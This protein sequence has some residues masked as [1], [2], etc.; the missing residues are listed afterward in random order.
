[1]IQLT[2]GDVRSEV[3]Q[4]TRQ[5]HD[6]LHRDPLLSCLMHADLTQ[7]AYQSALGVFAQ[8]YGAIETARNAVNLFPEFHLKA[9]CVALQQDVC[10]VSPPEPRFALQ[11]RQ[12]LLGAL[13]VA[14]GAAFGRNSMR[15]NVI[16]ALP[17]ASHHFLRC[18]APAH[19]WRA[20]ISTL[21][22]VGHG[23]R[24]RQRI[25]DGAQQAFSFVADISKSEQ[26]D[27]ACEGLQ[28]GQ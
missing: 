11:G 22:Q 23:P 10:L 13:Y 9:E 16:T 4:A 3:A 19:R 26:L 18:P 24:A 1:M 12:A 8:F 20:L 25:I 17:N 27:C 21:E 15:T 5:I 2:I 7:A 14:H 6:A 28:R